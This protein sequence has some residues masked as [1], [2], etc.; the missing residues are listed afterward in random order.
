[1]VG[2]FGAPFR[3]SLNRKKVNDILAN[4]HYIRVVINDFP[5]STRNNSAQPILENHPFSIS[6]FAV[7]PECARTNQPAG[8]SLDADCG[9]S[10][11]RPRLD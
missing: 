10:L 9:G 4:D 3:A 7:R 1:L 6:A 8:S 11:F 5:K 2:I